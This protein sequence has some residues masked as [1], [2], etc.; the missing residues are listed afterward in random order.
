MARVTRCCG[1]ALALVVALGVSR[2]AA[3][4][5]LKTDSFDGSSLGAVWNVQNPNNADWAVED[6]KLRIT[7]AHNSNVWAE[8]TSTRFTQTTSDDFDVESSALV[9][10]LDASIVAGIIA[11]SGTT[12]DINGR[13][14]EWVTLKLWGRG[15]TDNNAVLQ[16]QRREN[17][18]GAFGYVGTQPDY[19]VDQGDIPIGLRVQRTGDEY[20]SWFKPGDAGDWVDVG[21]VTSALQNPLE[22]GIYAGNA[23]G[24]GGEIT[25]WFDNF[26][27]ASDT[28]A[29]A[30][31]P[32]Y[33]TA[34][35]WGALKR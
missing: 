9:H 21:K 30:V 29:T 31:D 17:D 4:A 32:K 6:G 13:D 16:Y 5:D 8:D 15:G 25:A 34:V 28:G 20:Q 10:Y 23:D 18:D 1:V 12:Q 14:G 35:T 2:G 7:G 26:T 33:K 22:V 11:Y 19:L 27:E 24:D 3:A